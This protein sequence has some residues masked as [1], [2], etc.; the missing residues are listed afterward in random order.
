MC[1]LLTLLAQ[2]LLVMVCLCYWMLYA[3]IT[4]LI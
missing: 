1:C 4:V 2:F 3:A